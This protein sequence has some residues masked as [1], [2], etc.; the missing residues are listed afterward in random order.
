MKKRL[1]VAV[2]A[3]V[4][5][6]LAGGAAMAG[7]SRAPLGA[8]APTPGSYTIK[9]TL[10]TAQE[11][12]KPKGTTGGT[13]SFTGTLKVASS[14][15]ATLTFKLT[16]AHLTGRGL[17]AHVHLGASGKAGAIVVPLC[18][19][20]TSGA[21]ASKSVTA[22]AATAMIAGKAYVNVHTKKNPAGEIRGQVKAKLAAGGGGGANANPYAGITVPTTPALVAQGKALSTSFSCEGCHTLTGAQSTGPTWKGL[23]GRNVKLT[24]GETVQATD[25]Y[26]IWSIIQPDAQ[27]VAGYS[28]GI[29]TTAIGS[30]SLSQAK[31]LTAYIK[32]VK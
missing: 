3:V 11:V 16:Y 17:A 30:I 15:K 25:G 12:P 8:A 23:A 32:S 26:L 9:T 31:A 21:H 6:L 22:A 13:G 18:A 4:S 28:S 10:N 20:C 2:V 7:H 24:N 1:R 19:P 5:L 14:S 29:M 27:V